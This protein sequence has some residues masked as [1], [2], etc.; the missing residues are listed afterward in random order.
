MSLYAIALAVGYIA[1]PIVARAFVTVA[2]L[3][4]GFM[5]AGALS[6]LTAVYA[7]AR[8][9]G[10]VAAHA[11]PDSSGRAHESSLYAVFAKIKTSCF[12]TFA[13]GYFQASVVSVLAA[14]PDRGQGPGES[15]RR[16]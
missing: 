7:A 16:S 12:A 2:P 4:L 10:R 15:S 14:V 6:A 13:Y 1:G 11:T 9:D 3:S 8:L 5:V